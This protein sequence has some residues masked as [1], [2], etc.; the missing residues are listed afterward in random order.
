MS[1]CDPK[2][3]FQCEDPSLCR[4]VGLAI[5]VENDP[6]TKPT[7]VRRATAG[8]AAKRLAPRGMRA[9]PNRP[10]FSDPRTSEEVAA[11][12]YQWSFEKKVTTNPQGGKNVERS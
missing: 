6:K 2:R 4:N 1:A 3:T 11:N 9:D 12:D 8:A 10:T 7:W 5:L